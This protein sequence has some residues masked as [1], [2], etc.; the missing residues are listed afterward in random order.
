MKIAMWSGPR[1]L[2]TAMMYAFGNRS[3]CAVV[4]EPFYAAYL[5][6]TGLKHPMRDEIMESQSQ[7]PAEVITALTGTNPAQKPYFY[8]KHMAQHMIPGIPRDWMRKVVNVFLIR[9]PARVLASFAA[10]YENPG[11][12]DIGFRQ[13][14][15]LINEIRDFSENPVIID[16]FDIRQNPGEMLNLLCEAIDVPFSPDMLRWPKG[17]HKDDG[18]WA[19]HWYGTVWTST[20]F[21][22]PEGELP[23]VRDDLRPVL[24]AAMPLYEDMRAMAI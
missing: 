3:D 19:R 6:L 11:L 12:D 9:H 14:V 4:D 15:E 7:D 24:D 10:K 21:A 23:R 22:G 2:S 8:Q 13:Q 18:I 5:R 16:S 1:N 17:G 20:G